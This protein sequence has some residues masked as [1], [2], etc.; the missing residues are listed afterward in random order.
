VGFLTALLTG[1]G[2]YGQGLQQRRQNQQEQTRLDQEQA[3]RQSEEARQNAELTLDQQKAQRDTEAAQRN[4]GIDPATGKPFL[5]PLAISQV[6]PGNKGKPATDPQTLAHLYAYAN[7]LTQTGQADLAAA[8]LDRA[9]AMESDIRS[10][11]ALTMRQNLDLYNQGQSDQRTAETIAGALQRNENTVGQ[12]DVNNLRT[13]GTSAQNNI[14][15]TGQSNINNLRTTGVSRQN[16]LDNIRQRNQTQTDLFL[17]AQENQNDAATR[18]GKTPPYPQLDSF[19]K[20]LTTAIKTV[21]DNP[22]DL[23]T[24]LKAVETHA[25]GWDP[26]WVDYAK[27]ELTQAAKDA[28]QP[29]QP[30]PVGGSQASPNPQYP[31]P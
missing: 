19:K 8:T 26:A 31:G 24:I 21:T 4:K 30:L 2:G 16:T 15:T 22:K 12:S 11:N 17:R 7:W 20:G 29:I 14:R 18:T 9:K 25:S 5:M 6:V 13:T 3:Y 23:P 10:A 28:A 27:Q 1:V